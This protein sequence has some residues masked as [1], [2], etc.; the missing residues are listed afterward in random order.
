[1]FLREATGAVHC[2]LESRLNLPARFKK[3]SRY[4]PALLAHFHGFY[5]PIEDRI[6]AYLRSQNGLTEILPGLDWSERRKAHLLVKDL[7]TL[8][9]KEKRFATLPVCSS[10]PRIHSLGTLLGCA[11]VLEGATLGGQVIRRFLGPVGIAPEAM[12][13]FSAYGDQTARYWRDFTQAANRAAETTED[14]DTVYADAAT[15][16]TDT[17]VLLEK[18][19]EP[20]LVPAVNASLRQTQE[21][22]A[23]E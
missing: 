1:M 10:L 16:A 9:W 7:Q 12:Q 23:D 13:F 8:G 2:R 14:P 19:L 3:N 20:L 11:Y 4:Y 6:E 21:T 18:W 15:A 5:T 22:Q 17:F